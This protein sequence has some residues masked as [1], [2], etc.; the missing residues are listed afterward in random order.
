MIRLSGCNKIVHS[1]HETQAKI[2]FKR[3]DYDKNLSDSGL[4]EPLN[5]HHGGGVIHHY[6]FQVELI[7][8][9]NF[10]V[11]GKKLIMILDKIYKNKHI[12]Y[13]LIKNNWIETIK[14]STN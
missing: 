8:D 9:K 12:N 4:G 1:H 7:R 13:S 10:F 14:M 11:H 5:I 6:Q 3:E 2:Q